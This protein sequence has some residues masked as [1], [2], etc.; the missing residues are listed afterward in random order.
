MDWLT[1]K[2]A[3]ARLAEAWKT[4]HAEPAAAQQITHILTMPPP[5]A[6]WILRSRAYGPWA[7]NDF[8]PDEDTWLAFGREASQWPYVREAQ[9][10][11]REGVPNIRVLAVKRAAWEARPPWLAY[12]TEVHFPATAA[13]AGEA[14]YRVWAEECWTVSPVLLANHD[15]NIWG[16]G[17]VM[18][19]G[20]DSWGDVSHRAFPDKEQDRE[21]YYLA[22]DYAT[23]MRDLA[24]TRG[25]L[26][27]LPTSA[28]RI[29]RQAA[30]EW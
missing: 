27:R 6:P 18:L 1:G 23:T 14:F 15:V 7:D 8:E 17:G 16:A 21:A 3:D 9:R 28:Q 30:N 5:G 10:A 24:I 29:I 2:E 13:L 25:E 12:L 4:V 11:M 19:T 20:Y 22:W 26:V